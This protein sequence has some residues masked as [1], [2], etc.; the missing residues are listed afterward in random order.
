MNETARDHT[1][2]ERS[3]LKH[4]HKREARELTKTKPEHAEIKG[5]KHTSAH[6]M[7][8]SSYRHE[9]SEGR[10]KQQQVS[11]SNTHFFKDAPRASLV[12]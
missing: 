2:T 8:L 10:R 12:L 11:Q 6:N 5:N 9:R 7:K 1:V 3:F 4:G